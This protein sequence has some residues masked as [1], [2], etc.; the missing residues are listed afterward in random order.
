VNGHDGNYMTFEVNH[1]S[2]PGYATGGLH[3]NVWQGESCQFSIHAQSGVNQNQQGE[4]VRW[5]EAISVSDGQLIY[6][7]LQGSSTSWGLFGNGELTASIATDI[8]N[9][10]EYDVNDSLSGL[11]LATD[12]VESV[13]LRNVRLIDSTGN[14]Y[15]FPLN[16][17]VRHDS[18]SNSEGESDPEVPE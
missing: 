4:T 2:Q 8:S 3:L 14:V 6:Q 11:V 5:T 16:L 13:T 9:L 10:N 17:T 18:E 1:Q 12:G 15:H 7:I